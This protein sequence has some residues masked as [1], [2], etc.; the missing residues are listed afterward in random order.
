MRF[1]LRPYVPHHGVGLAPG[2]PS[3]EPAT[4]RTPSVI[5]P[6]GEGGAPQAS[7]ALRACVLGSDPGPAQPPGQDVIERPLFLAGLHWRG[8]GATMVVKGPKPADRPA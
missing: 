7:E 2:D 5:G 4:D 6:R 8:C 3:T 1:D